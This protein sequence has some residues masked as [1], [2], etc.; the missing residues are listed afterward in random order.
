MYAPLLIL[1]SILRWAV[2]VF[3]ALAL[4]SAVR[5]WQNGASWGPGMDGRAKRFVMTFDVQFTVGLLLYAL[6]SPLTAAALQDFGAAMKDP[7]LRFFAVEHT[8]PMVIALA[9]AHI[10]RVRAAKAADHAAKYRTAA[11]FF[12]LALILVL[13]ATPWPFSA[14]VR[15]LLRLAL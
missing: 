4:L 3:G 13:L 5:G 2:I 15:P 12:G 9:L 1:H 11:I 7:T 6:F 8:T 14:Q 10:G